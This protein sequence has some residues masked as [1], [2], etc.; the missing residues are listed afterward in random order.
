MH[1]EVV[2]DKRMQKET[3]NKRNERNQG[4]ETQE[5]AQ[6]SRY[7]HSN[8]IPAQRGGNNYNIRR[9]ISWPL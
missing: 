3:K 6:D 5:G 2:R 9:M 4:K 7:T 8:N 1:S